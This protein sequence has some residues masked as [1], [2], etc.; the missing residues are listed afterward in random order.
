MPK[1]PWPIWLLTII[2]LIGYPVT[3]L[4]YFPLE[5]ET[6]SA[7]ERLSGDSLAIP[8]GASFFVALLAAPLLMGLTWFCLRRYRGGGSI[9]V[10]RSDRLILSVLATLILGGPAAILLIATAIS[11]PQTRYWFDLLW[12]VYAVLLIVYLLYLRAALVDQYSKDE[13]EAVRY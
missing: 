6:W 7:E 13:W 4:I 11:V 10:W 3:A 12:S 5:V 1:Y 8:L 9:F 2:L